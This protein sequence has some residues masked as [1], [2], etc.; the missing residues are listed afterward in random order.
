MKIVIKN[1]FRNECTNLT[2]RSIRYFDSDVDFYVL[3]LCRRSP[4]EYDAQPQLDVPNEN[5]F[6]RRTHIDVGGVGRANSNNGA[7]FA[8]GYNYIFE[9]F[10]GYA[11]KLLML[12]EDHFFTTG[13]TLKEIQETDFSVAYGGWGRYDEWNGSLL[14]VM[15]HEVQDFFPISERLGETVERCLRDNFLQID[16]A[17]KHKLST[18]N[19]LDYGG[20]GCYTNFP[21]VMKA[22]LWKAGILTKEETGF[23][24]EPGI[25]DIAS[26]FWFEL[27]IEDID[28]LNSVLSEMGL[29]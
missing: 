25:H 19:E 3:N 1:F 28:I 16:V 26:S 6:Y 11:G 22:K 7:I 9:H 18:R 4:K 23:D 20:D 27:S 24:S 10:W 8:E 17:R 15:P 12:A 21:Q 2:I 29:N 5:I 13:K 14:C